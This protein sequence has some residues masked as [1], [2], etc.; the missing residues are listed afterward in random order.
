VGY[1]IVAGE[2]LEMDI[3]FN[4][5]FRN[6]IPPLQ[7]DEREQLVSKLKLEG[8]RDPIVIWKETGLLLD[9]HNRYDICIEAGVP[10]KPPT[11]LSFPDRNA[12]MVWIIQNQFGR[13]NLNGYQRA[14]L[15]LKL[16]EILKPKAKENLITSTGGL[17]P[18]PLEISP[19]AAINT[20]LEIAKTARVSDNT[21]AKVKKIELL[22]TPEQKV[23]LVNGDATINQ[24]FVTLRRDEVKEQ[25][26]QTE[27]PTGKYRVIY[28]DP[29]W[30]Y[31]NS[32]P[33]DSVTQ[34]EDHY[35][36]MPVSEIC[37]LP[38]IGLAMEDAVLFLWA[39]SPIL[40]ESFD[41]IE[42]WGFKYKACFV[43]DKVKHNMGHYNS[44]RHEFLLVA[45]RG[46]CPPDECKLYDS[47]Q[48]IE[49]NGHSE[50]PELFR[51]IIQTLYPYG[52]R[53]ELFARNEHEGW[54]VYGN[55]LQSANKLPK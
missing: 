43:W 44:V 24:I 14:V 2:E 3:L 32:M 34:Q 46:S 9:G 33:M 16:E 52:P 54:E 19:K 42:A 31:G 50:K 37:E 5:E 53:I 39:T 25:I 26:K 36:T 29:P 35:P 38:V 18:Q 27:W 23:K 45:T 13:R 21:I 51:D 49:R 1:K 10:L 47:V 22:A 15:A 30:Q 4:N 12:A 28:A 40:E 48:T 17:H 7:Q 55:Q 6:L 8:N 11:E 41:V 20:R